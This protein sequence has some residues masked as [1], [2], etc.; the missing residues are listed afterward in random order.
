M[1][2]PVDRLSLKERSTTPGVELSLEQVGFLRSVHT[3]V[4]VLATP[5]MGRYDVET[6]PYVGVLVGPSIRLEL[7]PKVPVRS[8]VFMIEY[9]TRLPALGSVTET[10]ER[11]DVLRFML[12]A[13]TRRLGLALGRGVAHAY[14]Q[15][16]DALRV[17]RGRIDSLALVARRFSLF[18]PVDCEF[19]DFTADT[20]LNRRLL[21]A[22]IRLLRSPAHDD[23]AK[24]ALRSLL[25]RFAEVSLVQ[26][27]K[28]RLSSV[29]LDRL[30]SRFSA[31]LSLAELVL[32][33]ATCELVDGEAMGTAFLVNM[34]RLFEDFVIGIMTESL[35]P[36]GLSVISHPPGHQLDDGGRFTLDPD[37][38]VLDSTGTPVLVLDAKYK[39]TDSGVIDDVYQML[40]YCAGL[41]VRHAVLVY[42]SARDC[43]HRVRNLDCEVHVLGLGL[44]GS[45]LEVQA[46][47]DKIGAWISEKILPNDLHGRGVG[48]VSASV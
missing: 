27:P 35:R 36:R 23:Q 4:K 18:P 10:G 3:A 1:A 7:Q 46:R 41:G 24:A 40:A 37:A 22:G 9:A 42:A 16:Y 38:L 17:P 47:A 12:L 45:D 8:V 15:S 19:A 33:D 43:I 32:R 39:E 29:H 31:V 6:G 20:E 21:A 14:R 34:D 30:A 11:S 28:S 44:T 13:Y 48:T 25:N 2:T 5:T 26:Y